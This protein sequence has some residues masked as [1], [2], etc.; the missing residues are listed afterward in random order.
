MVDR[1]STILLD[2][3]CQAVPETFHDSLNHIKR[4]VPDFST[5]EHFQSTQWR[6]PISIQQVFE[7]T[8]QEE[9]ASIQ[10]GNF[11]DNIPQT[12]AYH[13]RYELPSF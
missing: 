12:R 6:R 5:N 10:T 7:V 1:V 2:V 11:L 8:L 3:A 4:D 9:I 13:T